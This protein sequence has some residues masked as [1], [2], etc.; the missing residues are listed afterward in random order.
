MLGVS[1]EDP[2]QSLTALVLSPL[3]LFGI[4]VVSVGYRGMFAFV[5]Q[6]GYPAKTILEKCTSR[7]S[8]LTLSVQLSGEFSGI[9]VVV[10]KKH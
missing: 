6:R 5:L 8:P 3:K 7:A 4:D 9:M 10:R 1:F 2:F